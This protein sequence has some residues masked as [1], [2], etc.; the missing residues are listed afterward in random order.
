M[1]TT[2]EEQSHGTESASRWLAGVDAVSAGAAR[3]LIRTMRLQHR[4]MAR[5]FAERGAHPG[6]AFCLRL[7]VARDGITQTDLAEAMTTSRPTATRM[8]QMMQKAGLVERRVDEHDQRMMRVYITDA[9]RAQAEDVLVAMGEFVN[10][11][12]ATLSEDD[13]LELDR[14]LSA[15]GESLRRSLEARGD[16]SGSF[17]EQDEEREP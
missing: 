16:P 7:L 3:A 11:T 12:I 1:S 4:L 13:R 6:Q 5:L 8:L 17:G 2:E 15:F 14:L 9:G 10:E